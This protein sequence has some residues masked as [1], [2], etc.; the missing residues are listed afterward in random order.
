MR[1]GQKRKFWTYQYGTNV[2]QYPQSNSVTSEFTQLFWYVLRTLFHVQA[3]TKKVLLVHKSCTVSWSN[4][5][6]SYVNLVQV[7]VLCQV[8]Q[9]KYGYFFFK[10]LELYFPNKLTSLVNQ[11]LVFYV[12]IL[13]LF[14]P[15][16]KVICRIVLNPLMPKAP[17]NLLLQ[18][19]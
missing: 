4:K 16:G 10:C 11:F 9:C 12:Q 5:P 2:I 18:A 6:Y 13:N 19:V 17:E 8:C 1:G 3:V 7:V 14:N 15:F